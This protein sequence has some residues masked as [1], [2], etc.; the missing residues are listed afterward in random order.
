MKRIVLICFL[1]IATGGA[2][3]AQDVR[4]E[5]KRLDLTEAQMQQ[6]TETVRAGQAELDKLRADSRVIQAQV[7]RL[8]LDENP[9]RDAIE[10]LVR[11][12]VEIDFRAKMMRID[13]SLKVRSLVGNDRW[14]QLSALSLRALEAEKSGRKPVFDKLNG[15]P[16]RPALLDLLKILKDLN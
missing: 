15:T 9:S 8:L 14:A 1:V 16:D 5:L 7:A 13:R 3:R 2:M 11:Q 4:Q 12:G 6:V 10:K